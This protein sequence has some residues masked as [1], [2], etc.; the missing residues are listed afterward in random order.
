[1]NTLEP[2]NV[3]LSETTKRRLHAESLQQGQ[4]HSRTKRPINLK[5]PAQV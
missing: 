4:N 1:M 2:V 3:P 5:E